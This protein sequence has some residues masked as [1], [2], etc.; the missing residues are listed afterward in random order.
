MDICLEVE[1]MSYSYMNGDKETP[2]FR[3][4]SFILESGKMCTLIGRSGLG[5]TTFL[6]IASGI[7]KPTAGNVHI[8]D[9]N[10][11]N[12]READVNWLRRN[13]IGFVFQQ[14]N[15]IERLT[16]RENIELPLAFA[17]VAAHERQQRVVEV[18]HD[19]GMSGKENSI[20]STLSGGEKQRVAIGRAIVHKPSII[21]A[22]EPTGA[23]DEDNERR[24][25]DLFDSLNDTYGMAF[26]IITHNQT[27][28]QHYT[29]CFTIEDYK[30]VKR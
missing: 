16:V 20:A 3:D 19:V 22:D 14:F 17:K 13:E 12:I 6:K 25:V 18:L 9:Y 21:F 29:D 27:V 7:E 4:T 26:L 30:V 2:I 8:N 1:K 10:M 24:I 23:L 5:K 11:Y 28:I 15:L